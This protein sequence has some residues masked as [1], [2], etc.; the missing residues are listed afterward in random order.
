MRIEEE[1]LENRFNRH[2]QMADLVR[3]WAKTNFEMFSE[4][5][6]QSDTVS[7][8]KN[9]KGID[10]KQLKE[11]MGKRGFGIDTGYRKM[12]EKLEA[13]GKPLTF[14]IAHMGDLTK[15]EVKELLDNFDGII[16]GM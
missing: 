15:E 11:E 2:K 7:C 5:G 12:N 1:G 8:I 16:G 14:R 13:A 3:G 4:E 9:T 6:Y 10:L